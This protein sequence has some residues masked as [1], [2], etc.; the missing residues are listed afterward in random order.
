M[1]LLLDRI[2]LQNLKV[3]PSQTWGAVWLV[4]LIKTNYRSDLRLSQRSYDSQTIVGVGNNTFYHSYV[5]HGLVLNWSDDGSPAASLGAQIGKPDAKFGTVNCLRRM[6]QREDKNSLRFLPLDIAMEGFM[7]MYFRGP[8]VAWQEYSRQAKSQGLSPRTEYSIT[9]KS[10]ADLS[11]ALRVFEVHEYQVGVLLFI[12]EVL[13]TAFVVSHPVDYRALHDTLLTDVYGET[14]YYYG[15]YGQAQDLRCTISD[16]HIQTLAELRF[17][18]DK[19]RQEWSEFQTMM[20]EDVLSRSIKSQQIY[21]AGAFSL[22]RF[23]TDLDRVKI[24]Y[25]GEAI[26]DDRGDLQYLKLYGLSAA[27]TRRAYLL[28]EI[29]RH[30]WQLDKAAESLGETLFSL[31]KRLEKANLGYMLNQQIREKA[32]Q[33][34][35][36]SQQKT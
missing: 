2:S 18:L 26:V 13:A 1:S 23:V 28:Q 20:S 17:A 3:A 29:D 30:Q 34:E 11:E 31:V 14:F 33:E 7:S 19:M 12:G 10:I 15:L 16:D 24:N 25:I 27:Q 4:P 36:R 21:Q 9:G 5:P 22:Q 35:Y 32:A 8:T 6:A